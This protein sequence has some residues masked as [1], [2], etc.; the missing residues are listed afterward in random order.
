MEARSEV[1]LDLFDAAAGLNRGRSKW[2]EAVWYLMKR[3]FFL[4]SMPW[5]SRLKVAL[6]RRFGADVGRGVVIKPRVNIHLPWKLS[7]G[8]YVW[9]GEEVFILNLEP[10]TIGSHSCISQR[11][12]LCTGNH[13][14]SDPSFRYRNKAIV[15]EDGVWVGAG[16]FVAPGL[17]V[18]SSA[19]I[20]AQAVV[21]RSMP[22]LMVC[23]G[24]PCEPI[25]PRVIKQS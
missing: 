7:M 11:A 20:V 22:A 24:N 17:T 19:V 16:V 21:T 6:L 10:V 15:I 2:L 1:R 23:G 12:F 9:L 18:H 5:P 3:V 4:S 8:D 13:D 25:K 14:Y